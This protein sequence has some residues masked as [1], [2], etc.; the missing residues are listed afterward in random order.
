MASSS[1]CVLASALVLE[2]IMEGRPPTSCVQ[3]DAS[4]A[5]RMSPDPEVP[6][7][8]DGTGE[9]SIRIHRDIVALALALHPRA[10]HASNIPSLGCSTFA[11]VSPVTEEI[12]RMLNEDRLKDAP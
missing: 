1:W 4:D 11:V 12:Q 6:A 10:L 8:P 2:L 3:V 7:P 9:F 5:K